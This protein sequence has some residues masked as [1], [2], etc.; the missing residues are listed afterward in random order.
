M[1]IGRISPTRREYVETPQANIGRLLQAGGKAMGAYQN[2]K[3]NREIRLQDLAFKERDYKLREEE[4]A[5]RKRADEKALA[6]EKADD[7][8]K[9]N[10]MLGS[11]HHETLKQ[12]RRRIK[13]GKPVTWEMVTRNTDP[14]LTDATRDQFYDRLAE[15]RSRDTQSKPGENDGSVGSNIMEF[16]MA[17]RGSHN[18]AYK[19]VNPAAARL[20]QNEYSTDDK[21]YAT[22]QA[23]EKKTEKIRTYESMMAMM[24]PDGKP[25]Y[26]QEE[27]M[28]RAGLSSTERKIAAY[29]SKQL[30]VEGRQ[31]R[32]DTHKNI[33]KAGLVNLKAN[34]TMA[35]QE[36]KN[37]HANTQRILS[38]QDTMGKEYLKAQL[39]A[40]KLSPLM[41]TATQLSMATDMPI[42]KSLEILGK[43]SP[44]KALEIAQAESDIKKKSLFEQ[45]AQKQLNRLD[46]EGER[47]SGRQNLSGQNYLQ[48]TARDITK[49]NLGGGD[50]GKAARDR[51]KADTAERNRL[52]KIAEQRKNKLTTRLDSLQGK[53]PKAVSDAS[54]HR[55]KYRAKLNDTVQFP[56][57]GQSYGENSHPEV[58][59]K[60]RALDE[61]V[62]SIKSTISKIKKDLSSGS[63]EQAI[64]KE[65][66]YAKQAP[67]GNYYVQGPNGLMKV[68]E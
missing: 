32:V 22:G 12:V 42:M 11:M 27:A 47:Q 4:A 56:F 66:P 26:K 64:K 41:K 30:I 36:F 1:A 61:R 21:E 46:L 10:A 54:D 16:L 65:Y 31:K 15:A 62:D 68:K 38:S 57:P 59:E 60:Q 44:E 35:L 17:E 13:E 9:K 52:E 8:A 14:A 53:L 25:L 5:R 7:D 19:G 34:N 33:G 40:E 67:D 18:T 37:D 3:A 28:D 24:G 23:D 63:R 20:D 55:K 43:M 2:A 51:E 50:D 48:D 39:D 58:V 6:D 45:E 29:Q 49:A